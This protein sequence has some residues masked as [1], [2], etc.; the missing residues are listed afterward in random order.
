[1]MPNDA[2][3]VNSCETPKEGKWK[4]K[5][6]IEFLEKEIK[7]HQQRAVIQTNASKRN[8]AS[9]QNQSRHDV[10]KQSMSN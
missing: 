2:V 8:D 5:Q 9:K 6:L 3:V 7:V 4:S 10:N 1:M